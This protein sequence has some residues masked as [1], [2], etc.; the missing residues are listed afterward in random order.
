[1]T[2]NRFRGPL[3]TL[4]AVAV[5]GGGIWAANVAQ[6]PDPAPAQ[7]AAASTTLAP[8]AP[9][10]AQTPVAPTPF[11]ARADYVGTIATAS[12]TITLEVTINGTEAIAYACDGN[13][14]E[15][16]L[17]GSAAAGALSLTSK[18][19]G[20]RLD[21][22]LVDGALAGTLVIGDKSWQYTAEQVAAPAGLYVLDAGG[23]RTSWIVDQS[24]GV[25][26]VQRGANGATRPAP[27]LSA[28]GTTVVD[29]SRVAAVKVEGT[30]HGQ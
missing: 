25:T 20:S 24:G 10:T 29:G 8:A 16:W 21:G 15:S 17:R 12:G 30:E 7:P 5:L 4:G 11:P 27:P 3:L 6:E 19:G 28:D 18:D 14:V 23:D 1:M 9:V 2:Q 26:G 22:T 13:T